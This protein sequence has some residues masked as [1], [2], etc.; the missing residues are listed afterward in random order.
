MGALAKDKNGWPDM[1]SVE[2]KAELDVGGKLVPRALP[3]WP[4]VHR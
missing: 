2:L 1:I 3:W 4:L